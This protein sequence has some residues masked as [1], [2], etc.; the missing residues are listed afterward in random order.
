MAWF[1][2]GMAWSESMRSPRA[3]YGLLIVAGVLATNRSACAQTQTQCGANGYRVIA[4][5]WDAVLGREWELRQA[6]AH[7]EWPARLIA[8][9]GFTSSGAV[10]LRVTAPPVQPVLVHAGDSVRLWEQNAMVRIEMSGIAE[11]AAR[12]GERV[13]VRLTRQTDDGGL[14]VDRIDGIVRGAGDVEM[15]R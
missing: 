7:P 1:G 14:A 4:S 3:L 12:A 6:C 5:R 11:Q 9:S 8:E 10:G 2:D 15:E 13:I